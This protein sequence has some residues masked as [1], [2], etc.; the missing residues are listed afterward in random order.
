MRLISVNLGVERPD[1][2][3]KTNDITGIYKLPVDVPVNVLAL[4]LPGDRICDVKHHGG[5]D[6]AVYVYGAGD[7]AWWSQELGFELEPGTFGE[8]L[9]ISELESA[10]FRIG[11]RLLIGPVILE[12]TS[13]RIPCATLAGRMG[14]TAFVKR[15]RQA[16]RPGLYCRVLQEGTLRA[17]DEV[18][19][20][21]AAAENLSILEMFR[22]YYDPHPSQEMI[23]RHLAAPISVRARV[24]WEEKLQSLRGETAN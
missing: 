16:E 20:Q 9:T 12:V 17:G 23:R 2:R 5:P 4:G 18:T 15:Y 13:A 14:D 1:P 11:D 24:D 21:P 3:P 22:A 10:S 8:N 6:Q 19:I 7:Y